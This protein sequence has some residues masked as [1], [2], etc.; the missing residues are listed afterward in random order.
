MVGVHDD[1]M[2][3]RQ[4]PVGEFVETLVGKGHVG[5][6]ERRDNLDAGNFEFRP[7]EHNHNGPGRELRLASTSAASDATNAETP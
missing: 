2:I 6:S 1:P 3:A 7:I 4:Q 5:N